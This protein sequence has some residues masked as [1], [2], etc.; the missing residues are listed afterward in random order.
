MY[1]KVSKLECWNY[2]PNSFLSNI[3]KILGRLIYKRLY[4]FLESEEIIFSLELCFR[5]KYYNTYTLIHLTDKI[6]YKIDK[7]NYACGFF[8][9]FQKTFETV[10]HQH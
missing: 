6:R 2:R 9:G 5:E 4:N 10:D 7:G 1:R 8:V 3:E